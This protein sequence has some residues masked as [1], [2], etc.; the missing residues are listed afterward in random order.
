MP[1][2]LLSSLLTLAALLSLSLPA[3]SQE[4]AE[5]GAVIGA[6]TE[7]GTGA[8]SAPAPEPPRKAS[9]FRITPVIGA[10]SFRTD[11]K[12]DLNN[13]DEGVSLGLLADFGRKDV[14]FETGI[15]TL[16]S[17]VDRSDDNA[18]IDIDTW[19]IPLLAKWNMSGKPHETVFLKAGAMPFT[20]TGETDDVDVLAVGGI[21]AHIP[22]GKNSSILL[23]ATYNTLVSTE[24]ELTD[25]EGIAFLAGLSLNL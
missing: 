2:S 22:L 9:I 7:M 25:Y 23:D 19:G 5:S 18:S 10:S 13:L 8:V 11:E 24:G 14:V 1:K 20:S 12:V 3:L 21:G 16:Q 15:L 17:N 4:E 6:D